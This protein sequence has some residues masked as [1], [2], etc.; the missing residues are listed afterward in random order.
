TVDEVMEH[1]LPALRAAA[2][3]AIET[4]PV[5]HWL[6]DAVVATLVEALR[7]AAKPIAFNC[8]VE[9]VP[10]FDVAIESPTLQREKLEG[11]QRKLAERRTA[12]QAEHV[13]RAAELLR[14]FQALRDAAPGLSPGQVLDQVNPADRG[15]M[16]ETLLMASAAQGRQTLW[17]VAGPN[18]VRIDPRQSPAP[19]SPKCDLIPLSTDLGPLRSVQAG[20][21]E[22]ISGLLIGAQGGVMFVDPARPGD[23]RRYA[24]REVT[25]ALGFNAVVSTN[26][27]I[28]A[29]HGEAGVVAWRIGEIDKPAFTLR[30]QQPGEGPRNATA[31][32]AQRILYS[33]GAT[34]YITDGAPPAGLA[35]SVASNGVIEITVDDRLISIIRSDGQ[36]ETLDRATLERIRVEQRA[37]EIVSAGELP[38]L[39]STRLLL[40]TADGPIVCIGADDALVTQYTSLHRGLRAVAAAADVVAAISAD[41]QRIILWKSWEGRQP[42]SE[43]HLA[44]LARHRA[45]D[46]CFA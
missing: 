1:F 6:T 12:G 17:A 25:S 24:D 43:I 4:Q 5:E 28:W 39:G 45:A 18:L 26:E 23:A 36:V 8:G 38:W 44:N 3:R 22:G 7:S 15:S 33:A 46:L 29:T 35:A 13:A 31:L 14:Q 40:A 20:A 10:P 19:S 41:R 27:M 11:M 37:G 2:A 30:P 42:S 9:L 34:V 32:D 21:V 16:L